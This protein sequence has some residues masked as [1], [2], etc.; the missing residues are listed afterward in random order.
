MFMPHYM[1]DDMF[2]LLV[3]IGFGLIILAVLLVFLLVG[4]NQRAKQ[5]TAH[6]RTA[7]LDLFQ[8]DP[9]NLAKSNEVLRERNLDLA[10]RVTWMQMLLQSYSDYTGMLEGAKAVAVK[11]DPNS[12][13]LVHPATGLP[14][15]RPETWRDHLGKP[16]P[17]P[18]NAEQMRMS[19]PIGLGS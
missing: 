18:V 9:D 4:E 19:E 7:K 16:A 12:V 2:L 14:L 1:S 8:L 6:L 5:L 17:A 15:R 3:V 11:D 13:Q 10:S